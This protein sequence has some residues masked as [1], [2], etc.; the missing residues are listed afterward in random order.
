M[1]PVQTLRFSLFAV[2]FVLFSSSRLTAQTLDQ[3]A[4]NEV[5]DRFDKIFP[6]GNDNNIVHALEL[7]IPAT[8]ADA[9][10]LDTLRDLQRIAGAISE[11]KYVFEP[12]RMQRTLQEIYTEVVLSV[13]LP[14]PSPEQRRKFQ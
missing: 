13:E 2:V 12:S 11:E 6:H 1:S 8:W 7:P 3:Q 10:D 14:N 4:W 5:W 9:A